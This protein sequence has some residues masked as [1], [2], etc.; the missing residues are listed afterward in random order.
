MK[1]NSVGKITEGEEKKLDGVVE[2]AAVFNTPIL[3]LLITC[4]QIGI[5]L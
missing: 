2:S 3:F 5:L 4:A 1:T